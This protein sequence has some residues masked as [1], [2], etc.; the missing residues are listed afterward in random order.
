MVWLP[1][2]LVN[3]RRLDVYFPSSG[4]ERRFFPTLQHFA[5]PKSVGNATLWEGDTPSPEGKWNVED[6]VSDVTMS[7]DSEE[8]SPSAEVFF[9]DCLEKDVG[10][11]RLLGEGLV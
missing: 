3:L 2:Q 6:A 10:S 11:L 8:G 1:S 9:A 5:E 4:L 7:R